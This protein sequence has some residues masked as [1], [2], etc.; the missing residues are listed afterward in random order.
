[1]HEINIADRVFREAR[2][3][4]ATHFLKVEIGELCEITKDELEDGLKKVTSPGVVGSLQDFG[5]S[6]LQKSGGVGDL[7]FGKWKFEVVGVESKIKC[8]CGFEGRAQITD[9]G[10]GY[11]L[12]ACGKCGKSGKDVEVLE[13][14]EIKVTGV[15]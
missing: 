14:G 5:G 1:M 2:N 9:R 15:E 8:S 11:C 3:A 7:D 12:W 6:V 4:G 10:H 13:G